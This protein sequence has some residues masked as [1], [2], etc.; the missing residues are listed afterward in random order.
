[1]VCV[2]ATTRKF[3]GLVGGLRS[4]AAVADDA[5]TRKTARTI[6]ATRTDIYPAP[7]RVCVPGEGYAQTRKRFTPRFCSSTRLSGVGAG[8]SGLAFVDALVAGAG[9]GAEVTVVDRRRAPGGHRLHRPLRPSASPL[10]VLRG[11]LAALGAGPHRPVGE[12]P[13]TTNGRRAR[14]CD[15]FALAASRL[16][17]TGQVRI[18]T[19]HEHWGDGEQVRPSAHRRAPRCLRPPQGGR[20]APPRGVGA[21]HAHPGSR[22]PGAGVVPINDLPTAARSAFCSRCRVRQDGGRRVHLALGQ[23]RGAGADPPGPAPGSL[24][25]PPPISSRWHS[26]PSWTASPSMPRPAPR[27]RTSTTCSSDSRLRVG[28]SAS[29]RRGPRRIPR[30]DAQ[31]PRARRRTADRGRRQARHVRRIESDRIVLEQEEPRTGREDLHVDHGARPAQRACH[32][33]FQPGRIV[34]SMCGTT[35]RRSTRRSGLRRGPAGDDAGELRPPNP[36]AGSIHDLPRMMSRTW[37][38]S[39]GG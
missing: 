20:R 5:P 36:Y 17:R 27:R 3:P 34:S 22:S 31:P 37:R 25:S 8:A 23:P 35:R 30:H 38:R 32:P 10:G 39:D 21:G 2:F 11:R 19:E 4:G 7:P 18:L 14:I 16:T 9:A 1:M 6:P 29:T 26:R 28:W 33:I 13:A 15:C 24:V 12:T